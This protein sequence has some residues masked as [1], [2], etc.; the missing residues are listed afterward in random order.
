MSVSVGLDA[1]IPASCSLPYC[2]THR[3]GRYIPNDTK[4]IL[5]R[6]FGDCKDHAILLVALLAAKGIEGEQVLIDAPSRGFR[7]PIPANRWCAPPRTAL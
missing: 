6:R 2:F 7:Q 1:P 5:S 4:T 3:Q